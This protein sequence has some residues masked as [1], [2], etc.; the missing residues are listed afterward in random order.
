[1]M[2][3]E[4]TELGTWKKQGRPAWLEFGQT[5]GTRTCKIRGSLVG[6]LKKFFIYSLC[7]G[8]LLRTSVNVYK[9]T[10]WPSVLSTV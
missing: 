2:A 8:K 9:W 1:V 10:E 5:I 4:R 6:G 3:Q 7:S